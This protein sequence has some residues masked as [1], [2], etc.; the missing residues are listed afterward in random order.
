MADPRSR[1]G[2]GPGKLCFSFERH[3]RSRSFALR[4][5]IGR[6]VS[7]APARLQSQPWHFQ[8]RWDSGDNI[9]QNSIRIFHMTCPQCTSSD[10]RRSR[11]SSWKDIL[12]SLGG[13]KAF[14]C[15]KCRHRFFARPSAHPAGNDP[16]RPGRKVP[17]DPITRKRK[18][19]R[20]FRG[21]IAVSVL[22]VMFSLFGL[23]L[24]YIAADHVPNSDAQDM[25]APSE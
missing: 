1:I 5:Q 13:Q 22:V 7:E 18:L 12:R 9:G 23:F 8:S 4:C 10:I 2:H 20:L 25:N 19:R 3:A 24:R 17:L 15:R 14:R 16:A 6:A 11:D 21:I